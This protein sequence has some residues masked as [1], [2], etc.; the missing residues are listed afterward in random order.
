MRTMGMGCGG[1]AWVGV[2]FIGPGR[3]RRGGTGEAGG[4]QCW[5]LNS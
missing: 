2:P 4:R 1:G 5:G 3:A